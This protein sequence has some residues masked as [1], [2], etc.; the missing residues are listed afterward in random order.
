M[1]QDL[2]REAQMFFPLSCLPSLLFIKTSLFHRPIYWPINTFSKHYRKNKYTSF[3]LKQRPMLNLV[4]KQLSKKA[5][6]D[7]E[8]TSLS[9]PNS[10]GILSFN[11]CHLGT[12]Q[13]SQA[14]SK[15]P[16]KIQTLNWWQTAINA[17][18]IPTAQQK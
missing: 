10:A 11:S 9:S 6:L 12:P 2:E 1:I 3:N 7:L 8:K 4:L 17:S 16:R 18:C 14:S 15:K 13:I 5:L